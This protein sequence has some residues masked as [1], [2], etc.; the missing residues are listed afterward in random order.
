[1]KET[2]YTNDFP[3][4]YRR[5]ID[6]L[7]RENVELRE[8]LTQMRSVINEMADRFGRPEFKTSLFDAFMETR[9]DLRR[10]CTVQKEVQL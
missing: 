10:E 3:S 4:H 7:E 9:R 5:V 1:M 6:N 2:Q 8:Q